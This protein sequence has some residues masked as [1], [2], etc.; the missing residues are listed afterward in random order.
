M[1]PR[2]IKILS[3]PVRAMLIGKDCGAFSDQTLAI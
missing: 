3:A 1:D 2:K